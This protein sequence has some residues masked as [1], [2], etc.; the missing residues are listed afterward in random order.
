MRLFLPLLLISSLSHAALN[1]PVTR[2]SSATTLS[3]SSQLVIFSGTGYNITLPDCGNSS[4]GD[5]LIFRS[6]A[7]SGSVQ[8][9]PG[10][11]DTIDGMSGNFIGPSQAVTVSCDGPNNKYL[12]VSYF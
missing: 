11:G 7:A 9:V 4:D 5:T 3:S 10:A 6:I 8:I 12:F 2:V 1:Y